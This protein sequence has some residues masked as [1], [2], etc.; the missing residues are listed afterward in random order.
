M[1]RRATAGL[2]ASATFGAFF[3]R[4]RGAFAPE[5]PL[6]AKLGEVAERSEAGEGNASSK[7]QRV[8]VAAT[9]ANKALLR[10]AC[11]P[12]YAPATKSRTRN[13][14]GRPFRALRMKPAMPRP[15]NRKRPSR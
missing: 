9:N 5:T 10:V 8:T 3:L 1:T 6:P 2:S 14:L 7:F 12:R 11:Q 13:R 4:E 15:A